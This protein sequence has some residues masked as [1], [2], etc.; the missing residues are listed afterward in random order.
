MATAATIINAAA[1]KAGISTTLD[2]TQNATALNSLN[3][4]LTFWGADELNYAVTSE[5]FSIGTSA[6][7]YT[8]GSGGDM[9]TVRPMRVNSCYLRDGD[10]YDYP[11]TVMASREYNRTIDKD[12][13]ARPDRLYFNPEFTLAKIIFNSTPDAGY[14]AYFEFVKNF[15][16]LVSTT[17]TID[18]RFPPEY[19]G[20]LTDNLAVAIGE[21]W[22]RVLPA[23][24]HL[25]AEEGRNVLSR[26][27]A[28]NKAVPLAM[29][30]FGVGGRYNINTDLWGR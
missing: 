9:D 16:V 25:R 22:D 26:L 2:S 5:S 28:S 21:D 13:S 1:T 30:E 17:T 23:S 27:N 24:L 8:I 7:E 12:I 15:T 14:T 29:F 3:N 4:M 20:P 10:G 6:A 19:L 11:V 18:S